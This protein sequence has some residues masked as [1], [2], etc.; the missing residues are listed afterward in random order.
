MRTVA[1]F[2]SKLIV[3]LLP[4]IRQRIL[5]AEQSRGVGRDK[6]LRYI[7]VRIMVNR[8]HERLFISIKIKELEYSN[9][10]HAVTM[11]NKY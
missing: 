11:L 1:K 7:V 2:D 3:T 9:R 4:N 6:G 5:K 8:N 10:K